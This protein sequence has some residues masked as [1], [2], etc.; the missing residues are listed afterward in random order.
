MTPASVSLASAL[1][2][3]VFSAAAQSASGLKH[4][5]FDWS[6]LQR[7]SQEQGAQ[8]SAPT[9]QTPPR[10]RAVM[11]SPSGASANLDGAIIGIGDS[12]NGYRLLEV[13]EHGAVFAKGG[14]KFELEVG[15]SPRK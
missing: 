4:D 9:P 2:F 1:L 13:R 11:R 12:A 10:L 7:L 8:A 3:T 15:E 6:A 14:T 5:P